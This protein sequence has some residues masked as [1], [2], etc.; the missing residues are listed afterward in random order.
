[1]KKILLSIITISSMFLFT[2]NL[3]A[4]C[5]DDELNTWA[6]DVKIKLTMYDQY[7]TDENGQLYDKDGD[8]YAYILTIDPYREDVTVKATDSYDSKLV[9][10]YIA[11][12]KTNAIG[13]YTNMKENNY[14]IKI[15]GSKDS[16][17]PNELVKEIKYTVEPFN[18]FSKTEYCEKYPEVDLCAVFKDTSSVTEKEFNTIMEKYDKEH[19]P[20]EPVSTKDTILNYIREYGIYIVVPFLIITL[21]YIIKIEEYKKKEK[22][23]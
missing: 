21:I 2:N 22:K 14:T 18:Y 12:Y 9:Y 6:E 10:K 4:V 1:M 7:M 20:E 11:G 19:T 3:L 23:K 17:C 13:N 15:Y 8:N 5:N 16:K